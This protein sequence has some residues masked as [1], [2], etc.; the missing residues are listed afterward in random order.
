[1][2]YIAYTICEN[3]FRFF[4]D[5]AGVCVSYDPKLIKQVIA[6][7]DGTVHRNKLHVQ[8]MEDQVRQMKEQHALPPIFDVITEHNRRVVTEQVH[9]VKRIVTAEAVIHD[10]LVRNVMYFEDIKEAIAYT[11][12]VS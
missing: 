8:A 3:G 7:R 4:A 5:V 9:E 2:T 12:G 6:E 10:Q 1:M 11:A